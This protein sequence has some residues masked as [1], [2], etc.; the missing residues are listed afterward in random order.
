[1]SEPPANP[2]PEPPTI[3]AWQQHDES[4]PTR[5]RLSR[6]VSAISW[7][8]GIVAIV[9]VLWAGTVVRLGSERSSLAIGRA[10]GETSAFVILG[11]VGW[12]I[13]RRLRGGHLSSGAALMIA[14]LAA[15]AGCIAGAPR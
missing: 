5:R 6:S 3:S 15:V 2:T 12:F 8:V 10:L 4:A 13:L 7:T 14:L 9:L 11:L 1:M